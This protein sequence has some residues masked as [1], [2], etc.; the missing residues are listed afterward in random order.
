MLTHYPGGSRSYKGNW[1]RVKENDRWWGEE[2]GFWRKPSRDRGEN[3]DTRGTTNWPEVTHLVNNQAR[4]K[5]N[6]PGLRAHALCHGAGLCSWSSATLWRDVWEYFRRKGP[7]LFHL[8]SQQ[9]F[10]PCQ[11]PRNGGEWAIPTHSPKTENR[12][13]NKSNR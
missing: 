4:F 1:N 5:T 2:M 13:T 6:P 11:N 8:Q 7:H 12:P 3:W 10:A 9:A